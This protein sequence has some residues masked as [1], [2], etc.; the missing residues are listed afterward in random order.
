MK[1]PA[2]PLL[3]GPL[4]RRNSRRYL[5][6]HPLLMGLSI[7]GVALGVAVVVGIDLAND[8]ART[9]F[10]LSTETVAGRATHAIVPGDGALPDSVY[11]SVRLE[12]GFRNSAPVIEGHA[13][14]G[15]A[16][17]TVVQVLGIDPLAD[18]PFRT[19]T[20]GP[21]SGID[22]GAFFSG[23][24]SGLLSVGTA[25]A[26]GVKEGDW[27]P[28]HREGRVDSVQ[29]QSLLAPDDGLA[30]RALDNLLVVDISSAQSLLDAEGFLSR[31]DLILPDDADQRENILGRLENRLPAAARI[32]AST[33]RSGALEQM[34]QAFSL[35]LTAMSLLAM[36]VGMF[37]IYNTMTFSVVQRRPLIGR[38]RGLGVTANEIR[39]L[40]LAEA[41][42]IG[43]AGSA[44]GLAGGWLLGKGLTGL[45]TQSISDLYFTV[46]VRDVQP[47][48]FGLAKGLLVGIGGTLLA[49]LAPAREA[50][51]RPPSTVLQ[52][53]EE[54]VRTRGQLTK[55]VLSGVVL[56]LAGTALLSISGSSIPLSY[57]GILCFILAAAIWTPVLVDLGSRVLR[58]VAGTLL[59]VV[60]RM[61]ASGIRHT[62]SRSA[63]AIAA[64]TV[65]VAATSGVGIMVDSFRTTVDTWLRYSLEA[66]VYISPPG[67]VFRRNDAS[68]DPAVEARIRSHPSVREA[69]SVRTARV[70]IDGRTSDLIVTEP[71]PRALEPGRYAALPAYD[72][73][74]AMVER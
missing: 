23:P 65:A 5:A 25:A 43:L 15:S 40:I 32:E 8:S 68:I 37:L 46:R 22:L 11:R 56:A 70:D 17:G 9:A 28:L 71:R 29:I 4:L 18:E 16:Q 48:L 2:A 54:E 21:G 14:A 35:N 74:Q 41:V 34:T 69:Y 55:W 36:V 10:R 20:G 44:I 6:R 30:D 72:L 39:R 64:L 52:R 58:P 60:G 50:T 53:S 51:R 1:R 27:L 12:T 24:P 66:D 61:A 59:G 62:L 19:W 7:L 13:R 45:V 33:A 26:L 47:D 67:L 63:V 38:L 49:T 31:I 73:R 57:V 42:V 3:P